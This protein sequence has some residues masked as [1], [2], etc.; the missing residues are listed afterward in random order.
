MAQAEQLS[1]TVKKLYAA[2]VDASLW[3]SAL[4]AIEEFT[5]SAGAVLHVIPK[6]GGPPKTLLGTNAQSH[7]PPSELAEWERDY[8][9]SCPRLAAGAR[10]PDRPFICDRM[11]ISEA[12]MDRDQSY[13][14]WEQHGVRY[15]IGS[16]LPDTDRHT[17]AW[18]LQR[19]RRQGH[20]DERDV[21]LFDMVRPH[22]TQA[23]AIADSLDTL[24]AHRRFSDAMLDALPQAIFSLD[25]TGDL[26][27]VNAGGE[28]MLKRRDAVISKDG[29]LSAAIRSQQPQ[30]DVLIAQV[31]SGGPGGAM[32]LFRPDGRRP[33]TVRVTPIVID[34]AERFLD[35]AVLVIVSDPACAS[36]IDEEVLR[37]LYDLTPAEARTAAAL[38]DGHSIPSAAQLLGVSGETLRSHLK[39]VFRKV[40][41]SRQ[42]DLVRILAELEVCAITRLPASP[43]QGMV[44]EHGNPMG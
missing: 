22:L 42:Q 20:V 21:E 9:A 41:V 28:R 27:F 39:A 29:R 10:W 16:R 4:H 43:E 30:L 38:V 7:F 32:R 17:L 8:M 2:A 31:L 15:F 33:C 19:S 36:A 18:S 44:G 13:R 5:G 1:R 35:P 25:R 14:W 6:N 34:E 40:G 23:A 11:I 12:E 37:A 24:A 3:P 26:L